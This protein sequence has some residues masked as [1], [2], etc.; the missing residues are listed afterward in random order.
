[1]FKTVEL[2]SQPEFFRMR[3]ERNREAEGPAGE[4]ATARP[5]V[6]A[7]LF[8]PVRL[9][10]VVPELC[11]TSRV[12]DDEGSAVTVK[13]TTWKTIEPVVWMRVLFVPVTVTE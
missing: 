4:I 9:T 7:K 12:N 2:Q 8:R 13:S 6:P 1:M 10:E 11:P 3:L 5:T